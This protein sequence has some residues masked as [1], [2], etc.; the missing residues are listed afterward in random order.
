LQGFGDLAVLGSDGYSTLPSG[1][2]IQWGNRAVSGNSST[3]ITLP[4]CFPHAIFSAT[5]SLSVAG[6]AGPAYE[7]YL[8]GLSNCAVA[9]ATYNSV[10][11]ISFMA[12]GY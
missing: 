2:I 8:T 11:R 9:F 3:T 1:L 4:M 12:F 5:G 10:G 7:R 6:Y